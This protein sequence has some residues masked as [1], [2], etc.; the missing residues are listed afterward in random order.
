MEKLPGFNTVF[1]IDRWSN[2]L[3]ADELFRLGIGV[4]ALVGS[5]SWAVRLWRR[6]DGSVWRHG[7]GVAFTFLW[8]VAWLVLHDFPAAFSRGERLVQAYRNG[9]CEVA[10]GVVSVQFEQSRHGHSSGDRITI[11][12]TKLVVNYFYATPAYRDTIAHGGVL[13]AGTYARVCHVD[14]AIV[15]VDV[16]A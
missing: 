2:G 14:G 13:R 1:E 5:A 11:G 12:G 6:H 3:L 7:F 4:V 9:T 10:E 15:R 16:R 8:A